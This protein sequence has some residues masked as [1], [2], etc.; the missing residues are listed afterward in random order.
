[1]LHEYS[2]RQCGRQ[3]KSQGLGTAQMVWRSQN[4]AQQGT[5]AGS[6]GSC[7]TGRE[8]WLSLQA[9]SV[10]FPGANCMLGGKVNKWSI[11]RVVAHSL[12]QRGCLYHRHGAHNTR[13][14]SVLALARDKWA[15]GQCSKTKWPKWLASLCGKA[16]ARMTK[17]GKVYCFVFTY[18]AMEINLPKLAMNFLLKILYIYIG[19]CVFIHTYMCELLY[20]I[21]LW[22]AS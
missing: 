19:V 18:K 16:K 13:L 22:P 11:C 9:S 17:K 21:R 4:L 20:N 15:S 7:R 10:L 6:A 1:M 5:P 3:A 8:K 14:S 12:L 2:G